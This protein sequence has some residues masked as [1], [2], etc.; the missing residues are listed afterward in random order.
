LRLVYRL[1]F[2]FVAEDRELLLMPGADSDARKR[3]TQFY[4]TTRLRHLAERLRGSRHADLWQSLRLVMDL[5]GGI[6]IRGRGVQLNAPTTNTL[7]DPTSN[8]LWTIDDDHMDQSIDNRGRGVQSQ[9]DAAQLNA[10]T[11]NV[12]ATGKAEHGIAGH[13]KASLGV[14]ALGLP[15]LG[16][17]LFS[18][19]AVRDLAGCELANA[20]LLEAVRAL[21]FTVEGRVRRAVDYKNLG[22]EELGS[23]YESLLELHPELNADAGT[24]ALHSAS[25]NERK[26]T[27]SHYTPSS[28]INC[29][30]DSA[31]DPAIEQ[32][33]AGKKTPEEAARALLA[34]KVC[35]PACGSGHFLIGAAYRLAKRLAGIRTGETEPSPEALRTALREVI[36][37]CLYGVDINPMAVELCKVNLWLESLEPG[38]PLTFL[39]HHIQCGN[40]LMGA[41]PALLARG[42][43]DEAF[44][45]IEGDDKAVCGAFKKQNKQERA[46][47]L[48]LLRDALPPWERLGDLALAMAHLEVA[49]DDTSEAVRRKQAEYEALVRSSGYEFGRLWADAWCAAFMWK[50]TRAFAY[51]ITEGV[52]RRLERNPFDVTSWMRDEIRRLAGQYSFFHWHL[53]FPEVFRPKVDA[54]HGHGG[55]EKDVLGWEGGFDCVLG[56]PPWE[57]IKLQEE[58]FFAVRDPLIA[59][60]GN[61]D[62]RQKLIKALAQTDPALALSFGDAKRGAEAASQFFRAGGHFPLTAIGDVNT[63]ALFAELARSLV[64][65]RGRAGI[66]VPTGIA[67]DDTTKEFFGDLS[68]KQALVSLFDFE[69]REGLFPAVDSRMKFCLLTMAGAPVKQGEFVFF[70]T[71]TEHLNDPQRRFTLE[72]NEIELFNPNTKTMPVFR[73]RIDAELTREIYQ[74]V[75]VLMNEQSGANPWGVSF[76]TMFHVSN[77]SGLFVTEQR[78]GYVPMYEGRMVAI[79]DHQFASWRGSDYGAFH[80]SPNAK[81]NTQYWAPLKEVKARLE[82]RDYGRNWFYGIRRVSR[83]TD[84]RTV[85]GSVIPCTAVTYGLYLI[86]TDVKNPMLDALLLANLLSIAFDYL[87]RGAL[88][89]PSL[90]YGVLK[91][92]PTVAPSS[93]SDVDTSYIASRVVELTYT[94][95]DVK[96]FVDDVWRESGALMNDHIRR[97]WDD[98]AAITGGYTWDPPAWAEIVPDGCPL[99]PFKWDDGRRAVLRAELDAY[100][101]KLYGLTRDE[102]RYILD[103]KDVYGPDFPGETFR[104]LKEKEERLYGEYRTRRLVLEAWDRRKG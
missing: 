33:L 35:D 32:A 45:P 69:N 73:T 79:Y 47:Q 57:R 92:L 24:F 2:L 7:G 39:D 9:R 85:I 19:E 18:A 31:L 74:R 77:D 76:M 86:F 37:H 80:R 78:D 15:E 89:Q 16:S 91:Q 28:L 54:E 55:D 30:L 102:L 95:W 56:N 72:P 90:T 64:A 46:G 87:C 52:F 23:V 103:P 97:Q 81:P 10:P 40:S 65:E 34:L 93:Y 14:Q 3:Y 83:N 5:I 48:S 62:A 84:E 58:E 50:K 51:P 66:I 27:G 25:G 98:N 21:A 26:T 99:P 41:T 13:T 43:P 100:Y 44:A 61:K 4:S 59:Q 20:D 1:I 70:A 17:F 63:F 29:L 68:A 75:P 22:P 42:I 6:E 82:R 104:V 101:A 38:K 11:A 96:A 71:R 94:A 12:A 67:T 60:A 49:P 53:A 36:G 8:P 88:S